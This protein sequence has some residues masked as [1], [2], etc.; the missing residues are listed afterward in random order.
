MHFLNEETQF[1]FNPKTQILK[2]RPFTS[3]PTRLAFITWP[4]IVI[5]YHLGISFAIVLTQNLHLLKMKPFMEID[6][7]T[8]TQI[9]SARGTKIHAKTEENAGI[10]FLHMRKKWGKSRAF[11]LLHYSTLKFGLEKFICVIF[12]LFDLW[13]KTTATSGR[14]NRTVYRIYSVFGSVFLGKTEPNIYRAK[15]NF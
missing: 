10:V 1:E 6:V 2:L 12:H 7:S 3:T 11:S 14:P 15:L 9:K 5:Y 8:I 4:N 13:E